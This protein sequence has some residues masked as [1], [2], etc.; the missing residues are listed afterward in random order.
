MNC[1]AFIVDKIKYEVYADFIVQQDNIITLFTGVKEDRNT[2]KTIG[3]FS[4][5]D[6]WFLRSFH[7]QD[8]V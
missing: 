5:W 1:Y 6:A 4:K 8:C 3:E 7:E 2:H